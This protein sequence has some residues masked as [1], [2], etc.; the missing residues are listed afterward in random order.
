MIAKKK[1][2][3]I[4]TYFLFIN[5]IQPSK[6]AESHSVNKGRFYQD[7]QLNIKKL[8][9]QDNLENTNNFEYLNDVFL[10]KIKLNKDLSN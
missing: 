3:L 10:L 9:T 6:S 7:I 4:F 1:K 8:I 2:K 5:F